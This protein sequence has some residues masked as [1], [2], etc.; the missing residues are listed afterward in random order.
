MRNRQSF[1][2][3][4]G[5]KAAS[6][7][8]TALILFVNTLIWVCRRKKPIVL[9]ETSSTSSRSERG[10]SP[11]TGSKSPKL[12]DLS[13]ASTAVPI[14][15]A[16]A[17]LWLWFSLADLYESL[18]VSPTEVGLTYIWVLVG[19]GGLFLFAVAMWLTFR[20]LY[21]G[22]SLV[23]VIF[24][25]MGVVVQT[26]ED[27]ELLWPKDP[28]GVPLFLS[29][30]GIGIPALVVL[31]GLMLHSVTTGTRATAI[32]ISLLSAF[33]LVNLQ[34][35]RALVRI[36]AGQRVDVRALSF[37][38]GVTARPVE[39]N[40]AGEEAGPVIEGL[41]DDRLVYLGQSDGLM[42]IHNPKRNAIYRISSESVVLRSAAADD[43]SVLSD[44]P[45]VVEPSLATR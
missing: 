20:R 4:S 17:F 21:L 11:R 29:L 22:V 32:A 19:S 39:V 12:P 3:H 6:I 35:D 28:V 2:R 33:I 8:G 43:A 27:A 1:R 23:F 7:A 26:L 13:A 10:E 40:P 31:S 15:G 14:I 45:D 37:M 36:R 38:L 9:R 41:V 5:V 16:G 18:N 34:E 42:V 25:A 24:T 30:G 44:P